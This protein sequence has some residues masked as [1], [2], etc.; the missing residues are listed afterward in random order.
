VGGLPR[1]PFVFAADH[2]EPHAETDLVLAAV[3][4]RHGPDLGDVLRNP[5]RQIAPEQMHVGMFCRH[6]PGIAR[7]A[8]MKA[9]AIQ[10]SQQVEPAGISK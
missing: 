1:L 2:L 4:A 5:F 3:G 7:A 10:A 6:L 8:A 9:P